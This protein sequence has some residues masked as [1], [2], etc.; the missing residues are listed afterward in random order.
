MSIKQKICR[1]D[2]VIEELGLRRARNT[3][4]GNV[5]YRGVSGRLRDLG[6]SQVILR[7]LA[8][9][10]RRRVSIGVELITRPSTMITFFFVK[11]IHVSN[12]SHR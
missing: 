5:F 10:E 3:K 12:H 11:G 9:G 8:G 7:I 1:V 4:V 6:A 2:E